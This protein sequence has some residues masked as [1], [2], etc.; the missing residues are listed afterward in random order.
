MSFDTP[1]FLSV[2]LPIFACLYCLVPGKSAKNALLLIASLLFCAFGSIIGALTLVVWAIVN[3]LLGI[4]L[5]KNSSKIILVIGVV[6]NLCFLF[7]YKYLNFF[8]GEFFG[9]K[10]PVFTLAVPLGISFFTF[11]AISYLVDTYREKSSGTKKFFDFL[12]YLSFFP[13]IT[14]GPISR[15]RDFAP[16]LENRESSAVSAALG[17][18]RFIW[19]FGKKLLLAGPMGMVADGVFGGNA[20]SAPLAWVGALAYMMQIYFDFAAYSDMAIGLGQVFGFETPENFMHPYM[21]FSIGDFWRRWHLS[22]SHWFRDYLYIPLGGNRKGKGRAALNKAI[23]FTLCGFWHGASWTFLLWGFWHGI[24]SALETVFPISRLRKNGFGKV[25]S[26]IYAL[27]AVMLGFVLFR[28]GS[29]LQAG[30]MI[31]AMC[32][33]VNTGADAVVSLHALV[34]IKEILVFSLCIVLCFPVEDLMREKLPK[35]LSYA[36][37]LVLLAICLCAMAAS[38]FRPFIYAQF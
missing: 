31:A 27:L 17:L 16:Q 6:L 34:G 37:A 22:L 9:A 5:Q 4:L 7:L 15:F 26:H 32:G 1:L 10:Q 25:I 14:A 36:L 20:L 8:A 24:L 11:K 29:I 28:A 38:G 30:S 33:L 13:Q 19:G 21:A 35:G 23:V 3:F 2:F 18:R 12:L